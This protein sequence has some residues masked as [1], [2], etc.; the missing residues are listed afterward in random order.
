MSSSATTVMLPGMASVVV[1]VMSFRPE[2]AALAATSSVC[3]AA[4]GVT[5]AQAVTSNCDDSGP[6]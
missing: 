4:D 2:I 3:P 6:T 5:S 1:E